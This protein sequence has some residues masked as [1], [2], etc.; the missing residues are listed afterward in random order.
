MKWAVGWSLLVGLRIVQ[1]WRPPRA[2]PTANLIAT[3]ATFSYGTRTLVCILT[4]AVRRNTVRNTRYPK[5]KKN[6]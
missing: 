3:K 4:N 2:L 5:K 6:Q 1:I